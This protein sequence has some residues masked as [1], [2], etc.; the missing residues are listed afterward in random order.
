[1][2]ILQYVYYK[3]F[4]MHSRSEN[5]LTAAILAVITT[6]F[7]F[8]SNIFTVG[9]FLKKNDIIPVFIKNPIVGVLL[10]F[11]LIVLNYFLFMHKQKYL[12]IKERFINEN[13]KNRILGSLCVLLYSFLS[14]F[15]LLG[16][17]LYRPGKY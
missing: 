11:C 15:L 12:R 1:M 13:K 6:S 8:F 2:K 5:S 10:G 3:I 7:V 9:A 4:L 14:F 16:L 17:A